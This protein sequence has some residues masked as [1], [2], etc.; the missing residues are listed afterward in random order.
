MSEI[1]YFTTSNSEQKH[2]CAFLQGIK[3]V[4]N[5]IR[6][7]LEKNGYLRLDTVSE[8]DTGVYFC[9]RQ[10]NEQGVMWTFRRAINITTIRKC[11]LCVYWQRLRNK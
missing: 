6:G 8:Y 1:F 10:I 9:D 2:K 11:C 4:S 7:F 3:A 5:Q